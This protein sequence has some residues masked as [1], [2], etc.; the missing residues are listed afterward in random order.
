MTGAVCAALEIGNAEGNEMTLLRNLIWSLPDSPRAVTCLSNYLARPENNSLFGSI[1][2]DELW[3]KIPHLAPL[4]AQ[5]LRNENGVNDAARGLAHLGTNAAFA[6]RLL[7]ETAENGVATPRVQPAMHVS[8][9]PDFDAI[10]M[11]RTAALRTLGIIGITNAAVIKALHNAAA[12]TNNALIFAAS[13]AAIQLKLPFTEELQAWAE[14]WNPF[15][16]F[17]PQFHGAVQFVNSLGKAGPKAAPAL[18]LLDRIAS[19]AGTDTASRFDH[20]DPHQAEGLRLTAI[21]SIFDIEPRRASPYLKFV[22]DHAS[23][24][25]AVSLLRQWREH[26]AEIVPSILPHLHEASRRLPSAFILHGVAPELEEP[27]RILEAAIASGDLETKS[28]AVNWIWT[29]HKNPDEV[30]PTSIDL[31]KQ[32]DDNTLQSTLKLLEVMGDAA[33]PTVPQLKR[34]LTSEHWAVRERA[35]RLLHRIAPEEMPPIID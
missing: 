15:E 17:S 22:L 27:R 16:E 30:L 28:T 31:L 35:G 3:P 29:L 1:Y 11:R 9:G 26:R 34:L 21:H 4:L 32:S 6:L 33:R 8:Y 14:S 24:W 7:V 23:N 2:A 25:A 18:G 10:A 13:L 19:G 20:F 12:S 5:W